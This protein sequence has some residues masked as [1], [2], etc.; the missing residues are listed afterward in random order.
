VKLDLF[1]AGEQTIMGKYAQVHPRE[2]FKM[3]NI[4]RI[5]EDF[6]ISTIFSLNGNERKKKEETRVAFSPLQTLIPF[7][8]FAT[9]RSLTQRRNW[10]SG[11]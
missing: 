10:R 9:L 2:L 4:E 5:P 3:V 6:R 8:T 7:A 1:L 11:V